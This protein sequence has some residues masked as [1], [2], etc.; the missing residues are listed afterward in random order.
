MNKKK[1]EEQ[2]KK[3]EVK[4]R[5]PKDKPNFFQ[6]VTP[7]SHP[8]A[9]IFNFPGEDSITKSDSSHF[10]PNQPNQSNPTNLT[11]KNKET[12][13]IDDYTKVANSIAREAVPERLFKGM[14][15]NTYDALYLKTRGAV[16]PIRKIRA[17]R[18]D[19]IRWAGVSDVTIDKHLKHLKCVGLLKVDFVVGSHEGNWYEVF[20]PEEINHLHQPYQPNPTN[21]PKKVSNHVTNLVSNVGRVDFIE[22]KDTYEFP[23]TSLKT[24]ENIDDEALAEFAGA[25]NEI[26]LKLTK[27]KIS[28]NEK[29]KWRELAELLIMEL[30]IAA[31]RTD[32]ISSVPA[33]LTEH[34]RRRL[35]RKSK[36]I[37]EGNHSGKKEQIS[38]TL[39][40][41]KTINSPTTD[42]QIYEAEPL[43]DEGR[44]IVLKT[45]QDYIKKGER[46]FILSL[47]EN[48]MAE[49]WKWIMEKLQ[50]SDN[51]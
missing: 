39:Q 15:K 4:K 33:F 41:G 2:P 36:N 31:A 19:L 3:F 11:N 20:I 10:E 16:N 6:N 14:S 17:T 34:L 18:S 38:K 13:P 25:M 40:L 22:N 24:I 27:K 47:Q 44:K 8:V 51:N 37:S 9:E 35:S 45:M 43:T 7:F 46:E 48:Y 23:K 5:A 49:D 26:S 50:A 29:V 42:G 30:E 1:K 28:K 12:S 32:S 21:V